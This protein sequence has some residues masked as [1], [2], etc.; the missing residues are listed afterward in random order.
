MKLILTL[1]VRDEEDIIREN[2]LFHLNH[3][4]DFIIA[5]DNK[6]VDSTPE[7]LKEFEKQG[8]LEYIFEP[9]DDYSQWKWVTR[10]ARLAATKY[11]ADWVINADADEFWFPHQGSLKD[12]LAKIPKDI[13][14]VGVK[15][16]N[17]VT[18]N[19][20]HKHFYMD[21]LYREKVSLNSMDEPLPGKVCHRA[22]KNVVVR[23]GN[24]YIAQ[25]ENLQV[26]NKSE[27]EILH[28]PVRSFP[29]FENKI[30]LGGA[31][32]QRNNELDKTICKTWRNLYDEYRENGLEHYYQ[33]QV[34]T[35]G[36]IEEGLKNGSLIVDTRLPDFFGSGNIELKSGNP[37]NT[38]WKIFKKRWHFRYFCCHTF[39]L[40]LTPILR[41]FPDKKHGLGFFFFH[42]HGE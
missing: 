33:S 5:T 14:V 30:K 1:L 7:I 22:F 10:M 2:I 11:H 16:N 32:I 21:M 17:F 31:A 36:D 3:G 18:V 29:Q 8:V 37:V 15:R 19:R 39:L 28:F 20:K 27:I 13:S 24:H 38:L 40:Y 35:K 42:K 23:Q 41:I 6:S 26:A 9:A 12:A 34:M 4:V 25:P